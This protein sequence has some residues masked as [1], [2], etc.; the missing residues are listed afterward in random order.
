MST[1]RRAITL[2]RTGHQDKACAILRD[3]VQINP[4][5][6]YAWLWLAEFSPD[7]KEAAEAAYRVLQLRPTQHRAIEILQALDEVPYPRQYFRQQQALFGKPKRAFALPRADDRWTLGLFV[8]ILLLL[9]FV[10]T[11]MAFGWG[12]LLA[13]TIIL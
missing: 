2:G 1:L 4:Q 9:L 3:L 12:S 8:F 11:F 7:A 13:A 10:L 5:D 6:I